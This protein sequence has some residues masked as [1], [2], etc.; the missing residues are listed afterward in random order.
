MYVEPGRMGFIAWPLKDCNRPKDESDHALKVLFE[1]L[2]RRARYENCTF[3]YTMSKVRPWAEKL[4]S[5][6][7]QVAEAAAT[8]YI[9]ALTGADTA[10]I[11]D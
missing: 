7:M 1:L 5:Y 8:T 9:M 4:E 6:G 2:V 3:L 11:R 10:F